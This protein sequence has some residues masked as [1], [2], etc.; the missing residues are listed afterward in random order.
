MHD[1][2][3]QNLLFFYWEKI[4][5]RGLKTHV[6]LI[7]LIIYVLYIYMYLFIYISSLALTPTLLPSLFRQAQFMRIMSI[8]SN[9]AP[10]D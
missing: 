6:P 3:L 9:Y 5:S 7:Q 2:S 4:H 1:L 10:Q 8:V